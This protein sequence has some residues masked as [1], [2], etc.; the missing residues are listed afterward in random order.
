MDVRLSTKGDRGMGIVLVTLSLINVVKYRFDS[1]ALEDRIRQPEEARND[2][3][4]DD[5]VSDP[6]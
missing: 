3:L 1:R 5:L 2:K 4:P 6:K